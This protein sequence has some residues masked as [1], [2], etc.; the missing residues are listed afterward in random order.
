MKKILVK[1]AQIFGDS[2]GYFE[3]V[4]LSK[5]CVSTILETF[6]L[7][8]IPTSGHNVLQYWTL[9]ISRGNISEN[10]KTGNCKKEKRTKS[11][12]IKK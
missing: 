4:F 6:G 5:N 1:V 7:H 11:G 8:L 9:A 10:K 3:N 12:K 2:L